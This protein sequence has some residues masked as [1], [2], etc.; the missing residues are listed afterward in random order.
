MLFDTKRST[1]APR[2]SPKMLLLALAV[3]LAPSLAACGEAADDGDTDDYYGDVTPFGLEDSPLGKADS[4]Y[5]KGPLVNTNTSATQVWTASNAWEDTDTPAARKAGIAWP[6]NSGLN[7]DEKYALW[8]EAM[9]RQAGNGTY[10]ET[11][12]LT[13]PW[14]K[15]VPAPKLEC[16]E[17][18]M[19]MR[20][21]FAA[22]YNLPFFLTT[23]GDG[24]VRVY[25]GH[26]GAR[27]AT[28][29]YG[30]TPLYGQ[31]YQDHS[32]MSAEQAVANWPQDQKLRSKGLYGGGDDMPFIFEGAKAGA[33][34]DEIHLNKR[35]GHFTLLTLAYFGSMH[36]ASS[37]NTYNL[38]ADAVREGDVLVKRWKKKGIG[39]TLVVKDVIELD[40]GKLEVQLGSGSMPRRQPKWE[41]GVASKGYFTNEK[42][43]G[44]GEN[45][46][47][48]EYAR[49]G[50]GLKRFRVT[51]NIGGYWTNTWMKADEASWINDTNIERIA[52]RPTLFESLLGEVSPEQKRDALLQIIEDRRNHLREYPASCSAR[53]GREEAFEKLYELAPDLGTTVEQ[54]DEQYRSFEDRVFAELVYEESKT[55]CWNSSTNAMYQIAMDYNESLQSNAC[56]EPV[57]FKASGGGYDVFKAYAEQTNQGHLWKPWTEDELCA[58]RDTVDDVLEESHLG[59]Y[60]N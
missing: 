54:L 24:G 42:T 52:E 23:I 3:A 8:N 46:D 19:F 13:T 10:Y 51:K 34:F 35:V 29:R 31:W 2:R 18:A 12:T 49:L 58:Q 17:M 41:D 28:S 36:L 48:D 1:R 21:T 27:T 39:H 38:K 50:G 43:G 44:Q 32:H 7:W 59:P 4:A 53:I 11:F 14:G 40:G 45:S 26:F 30:N 20:I 5:V 25:F 57:V 9:P 33:Y 60:C 22:W 6:A 37:R 15:T 47:G 16:A 55:C 56:A